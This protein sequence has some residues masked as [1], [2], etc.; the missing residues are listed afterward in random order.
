MAC[1]VKINGK[2][3]SEA[4][5]YS[6]LV[7]GGFDGLV[8]A[9]KIDLKAV[10]QIQSKSQAKSAADAVRSLKINTK[11]QLNA[12]GIAPALF[13]TI[14]ETIAKG[15]EAGE[16]ISKLIADAVEL[17]N[18][19]QGKFDEK[20]FTK[21]IQD[22]FN[23]IPVRKSVKRV[24]KHFN[25]ITNNASLSNATAQLNQA[26]FIYDSKTMDETTKEAKEYLEEVGVEEA[27]LNIIDNN[28]SRNISGDAKVVLAHILIV[29]INGGIKKA[30][31][32][33]DQEA[34]AELYRDMAQL[35]PA[36]AEMGSLAGRIVQSFKVFTVMFSDPVTAVFHAMKIHQKVVDKVKESA[37]VKDSAK[38]I[39]NDVK[40][41]IKNAKKKIAKEVAA[42]LPKNELAGVITKGTTAKTSQETRKKIS[43]FFDSL[44]AD[45]NG[46]VLATIVPIT[47]KMYNAFIESVKKLVLG[48]M[49]L[50]QAMQK[51]SAEMIKAKEATPKEA[52]EM[53]KKMSGA[54]NV[55]QKSVKSEQAKELEVTTKEFNAEEAL[56]KS[57]EKE[58]ARIAAIRAK[59]VEAQTNR[60][61]T[62]RAKLLFA[63]IDEERRVA[64]AKIKEREELQKALAKETKRL[65]DFRAKEAQDVLDKVDKLALQRSKAAV[66][67]AKKDRKALEDKIK[68]LTDEV[69]DTNE[70]LV[71]QIIDEYL[72]LN[73]DDKTKNEALIQMVKDK[74]GLD[75]AKA[76]EVAT[77]IAN[78]V[79]T[80]IKNKLFAK[81][82]RALSEEEK[83]AKKEGR[84]EPLSPLDEL[85]RASKLGVLEAQSAVINL[86][87][88]KYG[89][90]DFDPAD[91]KKVEAM[92]K[93]IAEAQTPERKNRAISDLANFLAAKH[94]FTASSLF[95]ELWYFSHLSSVLT[96]VLGTADTN[97]F[98]NLL[99]LKTNAVEMPITAFLNS[100]RMTEGQSVKDV[101]ANF[102]TNAIYGFGKSLFQQMQTTE[103]EENNIRTFVEILWHSK[104]SFLVESLTYFRE[105]VNNG[106]EGF[107]NIEKPFESRRLTEF[108]IKQWFKKAADGDVEAKNHIAGLLSKAVNSSVRMVPRLLAASDMLF[109]SI[110]KNAYL[111]LILSEKY[112]K[113]G[114]R[115]AELN[116]RV[117]QDIVSSKEEVEE[118][119]E[120][121]I[122]NR[123]NQDISFEEKNGKWFIYDR[124][125][126]Y[127][128]LTPTGYWKVSFDSLDEATQ[129]ARENVAN[130]G[131]QFKMD[132]IYLLNKKIG[133]ESLDAATRLSQRD[134]LSGAAEGTGLALFRSL[135]RFAQKAQEVGDFLDLAAKDS[136]SMEWKSIRK[137]LS[138]GNVKEASVDTV[139]KFI[140]Y[141]R[142]VG[143]IFARS[144]SHLVAFSRVGIN[145]GRKSTNYI[146]PIGLLRYIRSV[147]SGGEKSLF[148]FKYKEAMSTTEQN[149]MLAQA[150][151]GGV[152]LGAFGTFTELIKQ[153]IKGDDEDKE[154][155]TERSKKVAKYYKDKTGE[156][157]P[158]ELLDLL[159]GLKPG[160][161]VGSLSFMDTKRKIFYEKSKIIRENSVY[162]GVDSNGNYIFEPL[163]G[164][165]EAS[166][167]LMLGA[168]KTYMQLSDPEERTKL[169]GLGYALY[170]PAS[171]LFDM[172]IGQGIGKLTAGNMTIEQKAKAVAQTVILDNFEVLN[173]DIVK[174]PLQ[175]WDQRARANETLWDYI[176]QKGVGEG[177]AN[178][179]LN[180]C[181]PVYSSYYTAMKA[182]QLYGM[183]GEELYKVPNQEQG[184]VSEIIAKYATS[185]KNLEYKAMYDW[186]GAN[187]YEKIWMPSKFQLFVDKGGKAEV[188]DEAKKDLYGR[189]AGQITFKEIQ[190]N[191]AYLESIW[192]SE[193]KEAFVREVDRMFK[194]NYTLTYMKGEGIVTD[195]QIARYAPIQ[196]GKDA[197]EVNNRVANAMRMA[198][199]KEAVPLTPEE[200]SDVNLIKRQHGTK[201]YKVLQLLKPLNSSDAYDRLIKY[202]QYN[203]ISEDDMRKIIIEM[204]L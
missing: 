100:I 53:R 200:Q 89:L 195:D 2:E 34:V 149:K 110:V 115:G 180:K 70:E 204:D 83:L 153:A 192:I 12:F 20:G 125:K 119:T 104:G 198:S 6:W 1:I 108:D 96:G 35:S 201:F 9:G 159:V 16:A 52:A 7:D 95:D 19:E 25:T 51:V 68:K 94:P 86:F 199:I 23:K 32:R 82:G 112:Y 27:Y 171:R 65:A 141:A 188:L 72:D 169:K 36:V 18:K 143:A 173:F 168:Y 43:D 75:D 44:K 5:F 130:V 160:D 163:V 79:S 80:K 4:E 156:E 166:F 91:A 120:K 117:L 69:V 61:E 90:E 131:T 111:P 170:Q 123:M 165:P 174:K 85:I 103:L 189:E 109:G 15:I 39:V 144:A 62:Q 167:A 135:T 190:K 87:K 71:E 203:A 37:P 8:Q 21:A 145:F 134:L 30:V 118:A 60:I 128:K 42:K 105:I 58:R 116:Q 158:K 38:K 178:Y 106:Q 139:D 97:N 177:F 50:A 133:Q 41:T 185:D 28:F 99:Q 152:F 196:E 45:P 193:G 175:Y 157:I 124:G 84:K 88:K 14:V 98:Y 102:F 164:S 172:S 146:T 127:E 13:N 10:G 142:S 113:E 179:A 137:A 81:Y 55:R 63:R 26:D 40:K 73:F 17:I 78:A 29:M 67:Q 181:L 56:K 64:E 74:L 126:L 147:K 24:R 183:F 138:K 22:T 136:N 107:V 186:L 33:N 202:K 31:E 49:A 47:P 101:V 151:L 59:E 194:D 148:G 187:G 161:I 176:E 132:L 46:P 48:G 182:P 3:M 66:E 122:N 77:Q 11:G 76:K 129:Y 155:E 197:K 54:V 140:A 150:I 162:K 57:I 154:K 93:K 121:A 92:A 114:L 191:M 184:F